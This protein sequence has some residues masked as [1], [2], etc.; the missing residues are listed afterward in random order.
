MLGYNL[1]RM[2][3]PVS[4]KP[5]LLAPAGSIDSFHAAI[6][7]GAD[8]VYLGLSDFNAR[9]RAKNFTAKTLSFLLP[10]AH[11]HN[12][13][14]YVTL[15][16]LIKQA[17]LEPV[18]HTLYQLDQI[19]V[20]AL[21]VSDIG[22]I[23]IAR[24][25]F[26]RLQLHASTQMA[27]HNSAGAQAAIGFGLKRVILSRE[28]T[29]EEIRSIKNRSAVELEVFVHGA[30]CYCVSGLCLAS[31]FLGGSS[32]N[33]GRCTQVCRRK[34]SASAGKG[35]YFSPR[36]LCG[37][38]FLPQF[39]DMG[40]ASFKIEGRMKSAAYVYAVV[41]AYRRVIDDDISLEEA[42][43]LL[44]RDLGRKKSAFFLGGTRQTGF[45]DA[46]SPGTGDL[47]GT[48]IEAD[49]DRLILDATRPLAAGDRIRLQ[50]VSGLRRSGRYPV[51]FRCK[52]P[53]LFA[54]E[55]SGRLQSRRYSV[56]Y[57]PPCGQYAVRPARRGRGYAGSIQ[58]VVR[59]RA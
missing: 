7:A 26:P 56:S 18:V 44:L 28:L 49:G 57:R 22:L 33:R 1:L 31:S 48:V 38:D 41:N 25:H 43:E 34:F 42:K 20:D 54:L 13:K 52:W 35:H 5:E 50:P 21:I 23:A 8:A 17:E 11:K 46:A 55:K 51:G 10:Y 15:N 24:K 30:F 39:S 3:D 2:H 58:P 29:I 6:E 19:G 45:I 9:L 4:H 14:L 37:V 59:I 32:G 12:V 16:T 27:V 53:L 40:I 47:I 36:D